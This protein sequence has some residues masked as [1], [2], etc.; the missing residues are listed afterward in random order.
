LNPKTK[1]D[2]FTA[3]LKKRRERS[4]LEKARNSLQAYCEAVWPNYTTARHHRFMMGKL[5]KIE[6]G[7]QARS[8]F[9]QPPQHGKTL[10]AVLFLC[11]SLGRD[12]RRRTVY[13]TYNDDRAQD[14]GRIALRILKDDPRHRQIFPESEVDRN[15]ASASRVDFVKGG[16]FYSVSRN[17]GLTGRSADLLVYDDV[18]KDGLEAASSAIQREVIG[19]YAAVGLT[20]MAPKAPIIMFGTRWGRRD[21]FAYPIVERRETGWDVNNLAALALPNDPLGRSE[22]A[23]LWPEKFSEEILEQRRAEVG[24]A[25]FTCLYQ[26]CPEAAEGVIFHPEHWAY[27]AVAPE[28]LKQRIIVIDPA[29]KVAAT[30]D[31]TVMQVWGETPTGFYLLHNFRA[32]LEYTV[33]RR[34]VLDFCEAWKP[35]WVLIEDSSNGSALLQELESTTSLPVK[36]LKPDRGKQARAESVTPLIESGRVYLPQTAPWL[37][38]FLDELHAFPRGGHDDQVDC[39]VYALMYFRD[40]QGFLKGWLWDDVARHT[41]LA[42]KN[43]GMSREEM[44]QRH[45]VKG[46]APYDLA[47]AQMKEQSLKVGEP[48]FN[49]KDRGSFGALKGLNMPSSRVRDTS[50]RAGLPTH[51]PECGAGLAIY[52]DRAFCNV[53]KWD[54]KNPVAATLLPA[55]EPPKKKRK[56]WP[57]NFLLEKILGA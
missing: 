53:C 51:C 56:E 15:A 1:L 22:G 48:L 54:S 47:A 12:P 8:Q 11:W 19:H 57:L 34:T 3:A 28:K 36:S 49:P 23:A 35:R 30:N 7:E 50:G 40:G 45:F 21:L 33:L 2:Q 17:G 41:E 14:V 43:P 42:K 27:Y 31:Y 26:G 13:V 6:R 46:A 32:R 44:A 37:N 5:E 52:S 39:V 20:R 18:F 25:V 4:A 16:S 10:L 38:D 55:V 24:S 9:S 29:S